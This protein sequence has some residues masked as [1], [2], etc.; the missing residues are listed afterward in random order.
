MQFC[1]MRE[2]SQACLIFAEHAAK[3]T[4]SIMQYESPLYGAQKGE[5]SDEITARP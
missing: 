3:S 1:N 5:K 2:Q 4:K